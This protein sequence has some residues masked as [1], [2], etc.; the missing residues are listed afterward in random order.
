MNS[1][2]L[3]TRDFNEHLKLIQ[4]LTE[5]NIPHS[6]I[7][8]NDSSF[9]GVVSQTYS[10]VTINAE[11]KDILSEF[12]TDL[13]VREEVISNGS[14]SVKI[15]KS[16]FKRNIFLGFLLLYGVII[17]F[18][19]YKYWKISSSGVGMINYTLFWNEEGNILYMTDKE[20]GNRISK[21]TDLN[22]DGNFEKIEYFTLGKFASQ[23]FID[24]NEDGF[25]EV[26][27]Y[28]D[29]KRELIGYAK[30]YDLDKHLEY[31]EMTLSNGSTIK[32]QDLKLEGD[33]QIVNERIIE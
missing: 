21:S 9:S 18:M 12:V 27:Y 31:Q 20:N 32:L 23:V 11:Y 30:D 24:K 17:S 7:I 25:A 4:H 28:Y 1:F 26:V 33:F 6:V 15:K 3:R 29:S 19:C 16:G 22:W 8:E 5:N 14:K 13:P 10:Q 2:T